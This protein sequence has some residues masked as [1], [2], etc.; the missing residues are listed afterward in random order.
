MTLTLEQK[1]ALETVVT[2]GFTLAAAQGFIAGNDVQLW[3]TGG[4]ALLT[5]AWGFFDNKKI[6]AEIQSLRS[7]K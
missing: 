6:G 1:K 4:L 2:I 3:I 5:F 7:K